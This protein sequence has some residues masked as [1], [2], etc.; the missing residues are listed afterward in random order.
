MKYIWYF[1]MWKRMCVE[2]KYR[3]WYIYIYKFQTGRGLLPWEL[4]WSHS[5]ENETNRE[6][7]KER[8]SGGRGR[9]TGKE[10][11]QQGNL[12]NVAL[13]Q[14]ENWNKDMYYKW[15]RWAKWDNSHSFRDIIIF[16]SELMSTAERHKESLL[17]CQFLG[18]SNSRL[19]EYLFTY[20]SVLQT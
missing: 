18:H 7:K 9:A 4:S 2:Q 15:K 10:R 20:P 5:R 19:N 12:I 1:R 11:S 17:W 16:A 6:T 8:D 3:T 13:T 14:Q